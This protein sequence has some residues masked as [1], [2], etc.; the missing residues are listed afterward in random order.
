ME[1]S[2]KQIEDL[3]DD[4]LRRYRDYVY[5]SV[6]MDVDQRIAVLETIMSDLVSNVNSK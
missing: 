4:V 6:A 2:Y 1:L 3:I 5:D